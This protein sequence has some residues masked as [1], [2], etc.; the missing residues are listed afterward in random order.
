MPGRVHTINVIGFVLALLL[1]GH[2]RA[3]A[4]A[5]E[6]EHMSYMVGGWDL[7]EITDDNG[8]VMGFWGIPRVP[9]E[10]GNIRRLWFEALPNEEWAV[11]AFEPVAVSEKSA[12]LASDGASDGSI[13]FLYYKEF[14]AA[15]NALNLDVDGG[16]DGLVEKGFIEGDPLTETVAALSDPNA[17]IDLLANVGYPIA[18]G[19]TELL[20]SG[21][22]GA[23]VNMNPATKQT[24]NCLRSTSSSCGGCVCIQA[25]GEMIPGPW[26]VSQ[27]EVLGGRIECNY[28]RV[29]THHYWQWGEYPDDCEEC[30]QGSADDPIEFEV[31]VTHTDYWLDLENCPDEPVF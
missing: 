10:V 27:E 17:M 7:I 18:P 9:V 28:S 15:D 1:L 13:Q 23:G 12:L 29:E 14:L 20:V 19:M 26:T 11:W 6:A 25:E 16:I 30:D 31:T 4:Q 2:G 3:A 5:M 24:L 22:A 21:T 8:A